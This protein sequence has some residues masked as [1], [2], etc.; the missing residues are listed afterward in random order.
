[1][2]DVFDLLIKIFGKNPLVISAAAVGGAGI[3]NVL[4]S[5]I[6]DRLGVQWVLIP[7]CVR[8]LFYIVR[9][10]W[11]PLLDKVFDFLSITVSPPVKDY[12]LM[13][14]IVLGMRLRSS[15]VIWGGIKKKSLPFYTQEIVF[16][17][18]PL[19]IKEG[20]SVKFYALFLPIR[21]SYAFVA[22]P[23]KIFGAAWRYA[24]GEW[25]KGFHG[26]KRL[27][28]RREQYFTFFGS[29]FWAMFFVLLCLVFR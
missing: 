17:S 3:L 8:P 27:E 14:F 10:W 25:K 16:M 19:L 6:L 23:I 29:V 18:K 15:F 28:I 4:D 12:I 1:M 2:K 13:G 9:D 21:L 20:D 22:W 26:N 7:D 11:Y 24:R 5:L